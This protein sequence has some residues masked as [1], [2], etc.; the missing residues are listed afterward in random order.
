MFDKNHYALTTMMSEE[1]INKKDDSQQ[2]VGDA[3][4][5][6][7]VILDETRHREAWA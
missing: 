6:S 3:A 4:D 7:E 5:N 2:D 1:S